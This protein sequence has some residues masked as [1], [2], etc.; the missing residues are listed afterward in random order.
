M[1]KYFVLMDII[2]H[3]HKIHDM[4]KKNSSLRKSGIG[5]EIFIYKM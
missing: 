4:G 1:L 2:K 5:I 3:D